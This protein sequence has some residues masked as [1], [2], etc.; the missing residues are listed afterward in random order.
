MVGRVH[1]VQSLGAVDGPGVRCVVFMQGCPLRCVYCHNPDTLSF[2]GGEEFTPEE[3]VKKVLR[4][5]PY[6]GEDG[7]V[8]IS[9][10]EPLSQAPFVA[11]VFE[12]LQRE[13]VHTALDT[14]GTKDLNAAKAV[15]LHT[16]LVL[17]DLKAPTAELYTEICGG[18]LETVLNFLA[19]VQEMGIPLWLRH[20]VVPGLTANTQNLR[21]VRDIAN[22]FSNLE[23]IEWLPF[24]NTCQPKYD[25]MGIPFPLAG[26]PALTVSEL[27]ELIKTI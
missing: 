21:A 5:R 22:G 6:W 14:A 26:T 9:G 17:A 10:G 13:G 11:K 15:L 4:F 18:E 12:L 2:S 20:V 1:S 3:L 16:D 27:E 7:G 8:T 24:H 25:N 19:L 23:K